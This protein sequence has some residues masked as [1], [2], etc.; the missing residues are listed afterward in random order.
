MKTLLLLRHAK[1][2]W[3]EPGLDDHDRPLNDRGKRDAPEVGKL[4]LEIGLVPDAILCS[5]AKRARRTADKVAK[6]CGFA[7]AIKHRDDLYLAGSFK[8]RAA[9][10]ELPDHVQRPLF[11]GHNPGLEEFL[12][13][14]AGCQEHLPTAALAQIGLPIDRWAD[15][16]AETR[17]ELVNIWRP[18]ERD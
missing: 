7:G 10:R 11:V 5:T 13:D 18:K 16:T 15:L 4:L 9:V 17:G 6:K 14:L 3:D 1:S 12:D 2:S 8:L